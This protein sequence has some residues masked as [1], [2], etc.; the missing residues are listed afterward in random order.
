MVNATSDDDIIV[1]DTVIHGDAN[2]DANENIV[3]A[4]AT[5]N[6]DLNADAENIEIAEMK[7]DGNINAKVDN[8]SVNTSNDLHIGTVSGNTADYTDTADITSSQ[9]ITNG[10][11]TN[12]TNMSVKNANLTVGGSIGEDKALNMKLA[13]GNK[14]NITAENV[15]NLHNTG[16]AANYGNVSADNT[17]ITATNDVNIANLSTDKLALTTQSENVNV[18][19]DVRTSGTIET[20]SKDIVVDNTGVD[21]YY[22]VDAQLH[23]TQKPM[24]LI[25]DKS[26][27]IRTESQNVT[28]QDKNILINKETNTASMDGEIT[29]ASETALRRSYHGK[30]VMDEADDSLYS[31]STV[32][33]YISSA[34]GS[35]DSLIT[36]DKGSL[37]NNINVMDIIRQ[38][39][40]H[41]SVNK[42]FSQDDEKKKKDNLKKAEDTVLKNI[43][44]AAILGR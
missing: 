22:D 23:L 33:D 16:A 12:D 29:L 42:N 35:R 38:R 25:V 1:K 3:I 30:K 21:P 7:L 24:H 2:I 8:L 13:E 34:I 17:K 36:D 19:G 40:P 41:R 20:A 28:R 43:N 27:N 4:D 5:I 39:T 26:N 32:S 44:V 10:L 14:V 11:D 6:G 31:N 15:A 37:I 9:S 18:T